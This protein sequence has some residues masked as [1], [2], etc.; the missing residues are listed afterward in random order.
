MKIVLDT[1]SAF[2]TTCQ[3]LLSTTPLQQLQAELHDPVN[4]QDHSE[5]L[6]KKNTFL[7]EFPLIQTFSETP[8]QNM[9]FISF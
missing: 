7:F 6:A 3:R 5:V 2:A 9:S 8:I 4:A 1:C